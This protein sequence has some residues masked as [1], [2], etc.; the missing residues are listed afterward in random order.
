MFARHFFIHSL[1]ITMPRSVYSIPRFITIPQVFFDSD[2]FFCSNAH[3]T[4]VVI[5]FENFDIFSG[6]FG[7]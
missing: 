3:H 2:S 7:Y 6:Y 5:I 1:V 4:G